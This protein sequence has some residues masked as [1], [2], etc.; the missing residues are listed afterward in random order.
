MTAQNL[1]TEL[2]HSEITP[3]H[4]LVALVEQDSGIVPSI[5]RKMT[6]DPAQVA[7]EARTL[8]DSLPKAYGGDV[9]FSP[10]M[11]ADLRVGAG[12]S[13][14]AAGRVRQHRAPVRRARHR[15]RPLPRRAAAEAARRHEGHALPGA[16]AGARQ[17]ARDVAEP[18]GDLRG[19]HPLR[20]RPHGSRAQ[21]QARS[22]HRPR[23]RSAPRHPG[24]VA[25]H[26][27]QP[28]ADR[29]TRASA[30]PPSSKG[31]RSASS[32]ATCRKG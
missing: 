29:R 20:P 9:R 31:S 10:R 18:G 16:D 22:G 1:A 21:G 4:L 8:L 13:Q 17:P 6:L 19:A 14:A 5:L 28:G 3:E 11:N 15:S 12:R 27:E 30:R 32:A 25:P 2:T 7:A 26:Q 23:R 24:A